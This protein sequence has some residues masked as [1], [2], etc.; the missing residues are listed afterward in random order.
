VFSAR[1]APMAAHATMDTATEEQCFLCDPCLH[2]LSRTIRVSA[3][4]GN[5]DFIG[6]LVRELRFSH[7]ELLL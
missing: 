7:C 3:V 6:E 2:I 1:P 5:E 4:Q